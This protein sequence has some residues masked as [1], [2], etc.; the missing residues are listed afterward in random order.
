MWRLNGEKH[1]KT[2]CGQGDK[3]SYCSGFTKKSDQISSRVK[4]KQERLW[5]CVIVIGKKEGGS[6][7]T[8]VWSGVDAD[9]TGVSVF[10]K[11]E[12]IDLK[13]SDSRVTSNS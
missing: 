4:E 13:N 9:T 1:N 7:R 10:H 2:R 6:V 11:Y 8:R 3:Y 12:S 5:P